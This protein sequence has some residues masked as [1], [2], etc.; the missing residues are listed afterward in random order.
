MTP[1]GTL[2]T[3]RRLEKHVEAEMIKNLRTLGFGVTKTSQPRSSMITIGTP[4]LYVVH[5]RYRI[6][7]WI[8][9]KSRER[10]P[11]LAQ[12]EW[13]RVERE[14]GGNVLVAW[15]WRMVWDELVRLG[16]PNLEARR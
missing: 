5:P 4:D 7:L 6:R 11:S 9:V 16:Y 14:A 10:L 8:E 1:T 2:A 15:S 12:Q 3:E 13:H